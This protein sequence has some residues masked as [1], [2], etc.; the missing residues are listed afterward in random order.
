MFSGVCLE[1]A[2]KNVT[3]VAAFFRAWGVAGSNGH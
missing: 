1:E 3:D 2:Y